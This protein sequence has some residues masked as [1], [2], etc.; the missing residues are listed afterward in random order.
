[1]PV[2]NATAEGNQLSSF[3]SEP[4]VLSENIIQTK[5]DQHFA[6][7]HRLLGG[8]FF[9]DEAGQE[10]LNTYRKPRNVPA[11]VLSG[12]A[13]TRAD[14][15]TQ[16]LIARHILVPARGQQLP[17]G[18]AVVEKK[19]NIIQLILA[20]ACNFGCTY[21]FEGVQGKEMSAEDE[22]NKV[23]TSRLI[24]R[25]GIKVNIEDSIYASK[26]RFDHQ[27]DPK[28]RSMKP[29]DGIAYVESALAVARSEGVIEVMLQFFGGEPLLNW[30]TIQAVLERF[31]NGEREGIK[32]H[33]S[34]VTNG[35]LITEEVARTFAQYQVAVCVS[36]DSPTSP[37]RPLKN[38]D[39]STPVVM[40]GLRTLQRY[41]NRVAINAALTS[42]TW[43]DFDNSIVD[44][45]VDVGA[46]EIGIVVDFDPTFYSDFGARNIVERLWKVVEYGR[47]RGVVLTGYWHQIF[48]VM[49]GFDS[50][51]FR[52]FKNCSAKGAQFS[53]EPNGSVFA[54]KAGSTLL[55]D[56]RDGTEILNSEP[57]LQHAR[58]RRDN[59]DFCRGC[60]IEGFC[61]GLCLGP[62]EKKF[63]SVDSVEASACDF[64]RGITQKHIES[65]KPYEVATF[66]LQPA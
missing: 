51:T 22:Y 57:Y 44:L 26:E 29:A 4:F 13:V 8:L 20:N 32:I 40:Q 47:S 53:I 19:I 63:A 56:I 48:Q 28:N 41:N 46:R 25:E 49:L 52:G 31:G 18:P 58:L 11:S 7:Y 3:E 39:D 6:T 2:A 66:D 43:S 30:R 34:T 55:G 10:L 61:G 42:S 14:E 37:S 36:F 16:Q 27:Y 65:L 54:C 15:L 12:E 50:V 62:L 64:Y 35:S 21:C 24:A 59:P 38:G 5:V 1:V 60:E 23:D 33:Y 9:L 45:A 17:A